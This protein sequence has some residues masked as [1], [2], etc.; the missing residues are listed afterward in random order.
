MPARDGHIVLII[1]ALTP[2]CVLD[3]AVRH[4]LR[5][6]S[7]L[8][9]L[10]LDITEAIRLVVPENR[11]LLDSVDQRV[12]LLGSEEAASAIGRRSGHRRRS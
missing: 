3:G 6:L 2:T 10:P 9:S 4:D 1:T 8:G 7:V 5:Y 12:L 11:T